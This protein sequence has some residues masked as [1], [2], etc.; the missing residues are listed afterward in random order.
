MDGTMSIIS[1]E[2]YKVAIL[3]G[4]NQNVVE[5][6]DIPLPP[7]P[8]KATSRKANDENEKKTLSTREVLRED[9][10]GSDAPDKT[11]PHGSKA[12]RTQHRSSNKEKARTAGTPTSSKI[13]H[14]EK[15]SSD[16]ES[17]GENNPSVNEERPQRSR[18]SSI[19]SPNP[20]NSKP[21]RS[22]DPAV[23]I[24]KI[25]RRK[26]SRATGPRSSNVNGLHH[27]NSDDE[28]EDWEIEP[29]VIAG[30]ASNSD[31]D[32]EIEHGECVILAIRIFQTFAYRN[33]DL[34]TAYSSIHT[35]EAG[36][37]FSGVHF[38]V[39]RVPPGSIAPSPNVPYLR[40]CSVA[41]GKVQV[42][43][44]DSQFSIGAHGMWRIRADEKCTLANRHYSEAVIHVSTINID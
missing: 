44:G 18:D 25:K 17:S 43:V 41:A 3:G 24:S 12:S 27:G 36:V 4:N 16:Y 23:E 8:T 5:I 33:I 40:V 34:D 31:D 10:L 14:A 6:P 32:S 38:Q 7:K 42:Q 20:Q 29:G 15:D 30:S 2:D 13:D 35:T 21:T 19:K 22:V 11:K 28:M 9:S 26:P 37:K 39:I 1:L